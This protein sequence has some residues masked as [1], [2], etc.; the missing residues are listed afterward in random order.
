LRALAS[1]VMA[2]RRPVTLLGAPGSGRTFVCEMLAQRFP[3]IHVLA[4]EPQLL[5]GT[6]IL[7]SLAQRLGVAGVARGASRRFLY[8][9]LLSRALPEND[10]RA[11]AAVVVDGVDPEDGELLAELAAIAAEAPPGRLALVLV[12]AEDLPG[13]LVTNGAPARLLGGPP[14]VSLRPLTPAEMGAYIAHRLRC[15]GAAE[16]GL[17]FDVACQQLLH[18]WSG[19]NPKLVNVY[20]HNALTVAAASHE[21]VI[22]LATL[23]LAMRAQTYLSADTASV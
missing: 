19:G 12:G 7:A 5:F 18:A 15:A 4:V 13:A 8:E 22:Q 14:P 16:A 17:P 23:R 1:L 6:P 11:I 2:G 21:R 10:P 20:C 3:H 9:V